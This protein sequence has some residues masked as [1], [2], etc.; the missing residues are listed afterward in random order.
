ML[1]EHNW[2][3]LKSVGKVED[4]E[5]QDHDLKLKRALV[6]SNLSHDILQNWHELVEKLKERLSL[7]FKLLREATNN[8]FQGPETNN[9]RLLAIVVAHEVI[10]NL[11]GNALPVTLAIVVFSD[12]INHI[13]DSRPNPIR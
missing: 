1:I 3:Q 12:V 11:L 10:C 6:S 5:H 8:L 13:F 4:L 9:K 7:G 2:K